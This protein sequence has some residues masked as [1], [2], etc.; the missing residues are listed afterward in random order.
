MYYLRNFKSMYN[1]KV[2]RE[3]LSVRRKKLKDLREYLGATGNTTV[4][5]IINGNPS[6]SRLEEVADFFQVS[7][8]TFFVREFQ[9]EQ[10]ENIE[11]YKKIIE[12]KDARIQVLEKYIK[13]LEKEVHNNVP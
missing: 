6:A 9:P 11:F 5:N 1:G 3:L 12:E 7:M 2:I 13:A 8:D 4:L 10:V